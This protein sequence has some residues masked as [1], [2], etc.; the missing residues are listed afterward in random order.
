[1]KDKKIEKT[2]KN[3]L[4]KPGFDLS[5]DYAEIGLDTFLDNEAIKEFPIVK[6]IIGGV[7]GI[8]AVR[9]IFSAKKLITFF[10]E[11]H[12]GSLSAEKRFE[13]LEKL[14]SDSKY[15]NSVIEQVTILN[16]RFI[17]IEKSRILSNLLKAHINGKFDWEGFCQLSECLDDIHTRA[18]G[19]LEETAKSERPFHLKTYEHEKDGGGVLFSAGLCIIH[20]NHYSVNAYGQCLYYYGILG[21]IDFEFP[22]NETS[23]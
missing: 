18:F 5:I 20:G 10:K 19:V 14:N 9:D 8:M 13:F 1:M 11:F 12:S 23:N 21:D 22:K 17:S 16:E 4:V 3:E 2:I 15:R 7:K 6:S